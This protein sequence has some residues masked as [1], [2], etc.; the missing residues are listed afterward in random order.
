VITK[1]LA[2]KEFK[3]CFTDLM[4]EF[5]KLGFKG[6]FLGLIGGGVNKA[7]DLAFYLVEGLPKLINGYT[8]PLEQEYN[9]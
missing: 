7:R 8:R 5:A 9:N 3:K 2:D 4:L 6:G 1:I